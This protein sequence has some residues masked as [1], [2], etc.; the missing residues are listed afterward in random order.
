MRRY[1]TLFL[2]PVAVLCDDVPGG[3]AATGPFCCNRGTADPSGTCKGMGLNAYACESV[4]RNDVAPV[5]DVLWT[6][7]AKGG[8]DFEGM[9]GLFPVGR[10]VKGFVA[11][12]TDS[13][14][15]G[16]TSKG[17]FVH[18]FIGCAE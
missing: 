6:V 13:V 12:S 3:E 5:V 11:N 1:L 7:I 14:T 18:A 4:R 17:D 15:L 9:A 10:D 8:C 2:A 16:P